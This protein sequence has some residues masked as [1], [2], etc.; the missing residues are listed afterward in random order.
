MRVF[1]RCIFRSRTKPASRHKPRERRSF[2]NTPVMSDSAISAILYAATI[3]SS[4][5]A[6]AV[7]D[8]AKEKQHH[9]K[10]GKGFTNPWDSWRVLSGPA[11]M[12]ALLWYVRFYKSITGF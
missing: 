1:F 8:E 2:A 6:G 11:I 7:P 3:S 9:L 10:N 4:S 5:I 12:K